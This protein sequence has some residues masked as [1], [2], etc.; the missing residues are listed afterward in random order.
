MYYQGIY[1]AT[2]GSNIGAFFTPVGALAG[3]MWASILKRFNVDLSFKKF[4]LYGI[5]IS[6]PTLLAA[7][8]GLI[9]VF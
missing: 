3:I 8:F 1:A 7:L 2:I 9:L 5:V 6:I 4:I